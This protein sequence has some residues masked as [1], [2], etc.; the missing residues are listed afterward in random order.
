MKL[1]FSRQI[2]EK[3]SNIA[4]PQ[5]PSSW[6]RVVVA[7]GQIDERIYEQT[8][9]HDETNSRFFAN[10]ANPHKIASI[11]KNS[12]F[13]SG[14]SQYMQNMKYLQSQLTDG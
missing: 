3:I 1:E 9:K 2:F 7:L 11:L 8:G 4:C 13:H 5:N 10:F 14:T 12:M 6:T